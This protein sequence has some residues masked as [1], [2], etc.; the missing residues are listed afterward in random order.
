MKI[1][2]EKYN[3]IDAGEKIDEGIS[4]AKNRMNDFG[5]DVKQI[6][7]VVENTWNSLLNWG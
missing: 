4:W 2:N 7:S 3:T 6:G 5:K 1:K